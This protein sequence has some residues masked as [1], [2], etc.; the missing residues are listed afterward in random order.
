MADAR[1]DENTALLPPGHP[2]VRAG[3]KC[4]M[5]AIWERISGAASAAAPADTAAA[6]GTTQFPARPPQ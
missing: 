4:P 1:N 2:P 5:R 3:A 6:H